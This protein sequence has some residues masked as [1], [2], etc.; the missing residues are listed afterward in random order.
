MKT[1]RFPFAISFVFIFL[2]SNLF[3]QTPESVEVSDEVNELE[4]SFADPIWDGVNI[5]DGQR[6]NACGEHGSSPRIYVDNIPENT[7]AILLYFSK[8]LPLNLN[9]KFGTG[10][11]TI[12]TSNG[13]IGYHVSNNDGKILIPSVAGHTSELPEGFFQVKQPLQKIDGERGA[14][15]PPCD[16]DDRAW[17]FVHVKAVSINSSEPNDFTELRSGNLTMG[18]TR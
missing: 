14:Y 3:S 15:L 5:P 7:D 8:G 17:Y 10:I 16:C 4:L 1:L 9:Q 12:G 6:C 11:S 13:I 2:F 18:R